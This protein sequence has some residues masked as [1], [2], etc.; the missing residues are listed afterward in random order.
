MIF[1][2]C[3]VGGKIYTEKPSIQNGDQNES[4]VKEMHENSLF[5]R[6][7]RKPLYWIDEV[8]NNNEKLQEFFSHMS[9]CHAVTVD[10]DSK[11]DPEEESKNKERNECPIYQCQ[12]PDELALVKASLKCGIKL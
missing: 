11:P 2:S 10:M 8:N 4:N 12:S 6:N 5:A 3:T 9:I 7:E 1:K